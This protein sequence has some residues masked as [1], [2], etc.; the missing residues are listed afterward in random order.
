MLED[1]LVDLATKPRIGC[2]GRR[3]EGGRLGNSALFAT[4]FD[5]GSRVMSSGWSGV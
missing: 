1:A 5:A 4:V 3:R 2:D